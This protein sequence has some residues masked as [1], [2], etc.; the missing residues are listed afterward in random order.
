[1]TKIEG[2]CYIL[3]DGIIWIKT[4]LNRVQSECCN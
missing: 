1:M 3:K 4:N 2:N